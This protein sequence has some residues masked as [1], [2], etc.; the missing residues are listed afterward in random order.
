VHTEVNV[1]KV[2]EDN[3]QYVDVGRE[4]EG[5]VKGWVGGDFSKDVGGTGVKALSWST[6]YESEKEWGW[7]PAKPVSC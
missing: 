7:L 1:D 5:R 4:E 2:R 6:Q 3:G